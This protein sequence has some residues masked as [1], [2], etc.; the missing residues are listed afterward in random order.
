MLQAKVVLTPPH[1]AFWISNIWIR[2]TINS[3]H[4]PAWYD[5]PARFHFTG[6]FAKR[7]AGRL[8][9]G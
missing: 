5:L 7:A 4:N 9:H 3:L 1:H 2:S 6:G 8:L